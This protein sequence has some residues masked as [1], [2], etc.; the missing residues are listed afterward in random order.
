MAE[1]NNMQ[2]SGSV[3][4][5]NDD[6][7]STVVSEGW[8]MGEEGEGTDNNN[9]NDEFIAKLTD[10]RMATLEAEMKNKFNKEQTTGLSLFFV[11]G[12]N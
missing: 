3:S 9:N 8:E 12:E 2:R 10:L 11:N 7:R 4:T 5:L 6:G 1:M